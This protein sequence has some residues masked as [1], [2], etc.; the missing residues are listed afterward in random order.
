MGSDDPSRVRAHC[1]HAV[2]TWGT[3]VPARGDRRRD[4]RVTVTRA[5]WW[6][7]AVL[8]QIYPRSWADGDGD[9]VGDLPG[10]TGHLD[11]QP[12]L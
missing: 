3:V 11:H 2:I 9:G 4:E 7:D 12:H 10:I 5:Q 1:R 8:Y 6:R